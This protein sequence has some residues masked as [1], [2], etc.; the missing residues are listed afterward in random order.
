MT[1]AVESCPA[2]RLSIS[3]ARMDIRSPERD[4]LLMLLAMAAGS[5]DAWSYFGIGHSFVA[6]MTGNTVL[7]GV[8]IVRANGDW[9]HPLIS[10]CGYAAGVMAGANVTRRINPESAWPRA[11]SWALLLE[12]VLMSIAEAAWTLISQ[13][14]TTFSIERNLLLVAIA[15]AVGIQSGAMLQMRIPG[16]VTTYITGTWTSLMSEVA[17]LLSRGGKPPT[18]EVRRMEERVLLQ[19]GILTA[20][21]LSAIATGVLLRYA[22]AAT[23]ALP[24]T[25]VWIVVILGLR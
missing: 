11:V 5:A 15:F 25:A 13:A 10:L 6:N 14:N 4:V 2:Q 9:L 3:T 21:V 17:R 1:R 23:G 16:V 12:A 19:A 18:R 22:P 7:I 24:A 20:Y 8:A